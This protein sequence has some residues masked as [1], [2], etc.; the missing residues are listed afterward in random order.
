MFLSR[1]K[2][3]NRSRKHQVVFES[4]FRKELGLGPFGDIC[5]VLV[6]ELLQ[7]AVLHKLFM[8]VF[9]EQVKFLVSFFASKA[10]PCDSIYLCRSL[11]CSTPITK[12]PNLHPLLFSSL[13]KFQCNAGAESNSNAS[14]FSRHPFLC[15]HSHLF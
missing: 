13:D 9:H 15:I 2:D 10:Q 11:C 4:N 1:S 14:S 12:A 6:E 3:K 8:V 5:V 7:L